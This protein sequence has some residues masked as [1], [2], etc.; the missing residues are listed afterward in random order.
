MQCT[1]CSG[2]TKVVSTAHV[3]TDLTKRRR[4]CLRCGVRITSY[5]RPERPPEEDRQDMEA[6]RREREAARRKIDEILLKL[7][8]AA[9]CLEE[10]E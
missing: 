5:E 7:H 2:E 3:R 1:T 10:M 9:Q 6:A 8:Q 4:E